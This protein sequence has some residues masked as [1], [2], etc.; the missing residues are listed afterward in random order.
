[1]SGDFHDR[2][3][4]DE[5]STALFAFD[6]NSVTAK[7][8]SL[9]GFKD[10]TIRTFMKFRQKGFV[11]RNKKD[12]TKVYGISEKEY[13]RLAPYIIIGRTGTPA[14][15]SG[16]SKDR[17]TFASQVQKST[18]ELNTADSS[19]LLAIN[20]I[21]PSFSKR[22]LKYRMLLG[23]Y[24]SVEQLK[25]VY[26]F[27]PELFEKVSG[28]FTADPSLITK[29]KVNKDDFKTVNKHPYISYE[30]TKLLF[31][32]RR[33]TMLNAANFKEIVADDALYARVLPYISFE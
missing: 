23:G 9:L 6:P 5:N 30:L 14:K 21:G 31:D 33:K 8:L 27:T 29:V 11:F 19:A 16:G 2:F 3:P 32:W 28:S 17:K 10:K 12:L 15:N 25:E 4:V 1:V 20:G 26:G 13:A 22:I 7:Q 24:T 18:V